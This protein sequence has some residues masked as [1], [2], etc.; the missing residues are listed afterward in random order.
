MRTLPISVFILL[1]LTM[2]K[3]DLKKHFDAIVES[4]LDGVDLRYGIIDRALVEK[5]H[6]SGLDVWCWTVN[7]PYTALK[8]RQ[9]G[10]SA[11]TTDHPAWLKENL[12]TED[13]PFFP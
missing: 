3:P 11:V 1:H 5:C 4:R 13:D 2:F 9:M 10:V 12:D 6:E 7:D 8:M